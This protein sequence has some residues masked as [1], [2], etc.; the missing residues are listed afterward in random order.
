MTTTPSVDV[1]GQIAD[2]MAAC[3][4][5]PLRHVLI[6]YPWG[7]SI[8]EG[9]DGPDVWQRE[10]LIE[11]GEQVKSR[12][13]DGINAVDP[14][15]FSTASGHGI[16][17]S[18]MTAWIIR[19]IADTRPFS[20]GVVTANTSEQLRTKTWSELAKWHHMGLTK[21][22]Y[23]LNAGG[24]GSMNMYHRQ[25]KET[26]RVDAHTS[27][28]ENSEA[29][30]GLH[31]ANSTPYYI[32]DEAGGIPDKIFEVREGGL[33]DGEP[34]VF[35]WGNPTRNSGRFHAN[36]I[37]KYR[38]RFIRRH[39]DSRKVRITNKAYIN[40]LIEDYGIDSDYVKVR[41]LGTFPSASMHQFI[42]TD[43]VDAAM[44]REMTPREYNFAPTIIGVDP[45]WTGDD[46][47]AIYLRQGLNSKRLGTYDKNDNDVQM[48][49]LIAQF[50][51][52]HD[53]DA[54]FIDGGF[55]TGIVSIGHTMGR[56]N[57]QIVWFSSKSMDIGCFNKRAE[58]WNSMRKWL[59]EGAALEEDDIM[60]SD[61]TAP[62]LVP[63]LDGKIHL[64]SKEHMRAR[65]LASPNRADALAITF[66]FPVASKKLAYNPKQEAE[67]QHEYD[68]LG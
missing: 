37:G 34:M 3:Y 63:R 13:F 23:V 14:I 40:R 36:M 52:D 33:T 10:F 30:A 38:H 24:Q 6:S 56:D 7:S 19:W 4:A 51:D 44:R 8:L 58:M 28:A 27:K 60:L 20:K 62:E 66:A 15:Q 5:D 64:E 26:W 48:A 47:F 32:F 42:S 25:H 59:K 31:A 50:E 45:A 68:P 55:G 54:V 16:G 39:I 1:D 67:T 17:K 22:W 21:H 57:W 12:G 35:D 18:C 9:H 49:Q 65:G 41:V 53:A 11:V 2:E 29:F 61:L 46:E 43:D